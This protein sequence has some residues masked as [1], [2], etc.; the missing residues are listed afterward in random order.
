MKKWINVKKKKINVRCPCLSEPSSITR[1]DYVVFAFRDV[2]FPLLKSNLA[3]ACRK[4]LFS[5]AATVHDSTSFMKIMDLDM[6]HQKQD[7]GI[8]TMPK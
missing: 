8:Y 2:Y 3:F 7:P 1:P 6:S 5:N 4:S